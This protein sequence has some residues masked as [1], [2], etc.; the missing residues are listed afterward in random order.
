MSVVGTTL[1]ALLAGRRGGTVRIFDR[2]LRIFG[3]RATPAF[4]LAANGLWVLCTVAVVILGSLFAYYCMFAAIAVE[5]IAA[6][7]YT[8][9]LN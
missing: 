5:F 6:V 7:Y 1:L 2:N 4:L 3:K 8:F 9:Q